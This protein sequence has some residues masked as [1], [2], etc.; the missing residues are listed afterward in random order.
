LPTLRPRPHRQI[1][2]AVF[3]RISFR[4]SRAFGYP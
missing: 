3:D 1:A 2:Q 4:E